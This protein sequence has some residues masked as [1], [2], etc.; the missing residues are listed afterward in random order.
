M[1]EPRAPTVAWFARSALRT[2]VEEDAQ[3]GPVETG[4]VLV[5]YWVSA[6]EV[7]ITEATTAGPG[8]RH[9]PKAYLPD[10]E[11]DA[12]EIA[13]FYASSARTHVYL[14]DWHSHPSGGLG[15]SRRDRQTLRRIARHEDAQ[16]PEPLM[17]VVGESGD[18]L[19]VA[20][21]VLRRH[22]ARDRAESCRVRVFGRPTR[23]ADPPP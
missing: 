14:G 3:H 20:V 7:V 9:E 22:G 4:G 12:R 17:A 6:A 11:H 2:I 13:R 15:L 23:P 19:A 21:W 10:A 16:A 1:S 18:A 5:G 8:A